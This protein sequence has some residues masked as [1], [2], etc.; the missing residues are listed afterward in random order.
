MAITAYFDG[1]WNDEAPAVMAVG[2]FLSSEKRWRWFED[3]WAKLLAEFG[4][5]YFQMREFTTCSGQF[6]GWKAREPDRREFIRRATDLIGKVAWQS[7]AAAV[8]KDDWN[9]CNEGYALDENRFYPYPLCGWACIQHVQIWC[10]NQKRPYPLGQ[11]LYFFEKDDPNQDDLRKRA[12][13]D[14]GIAIRTPKAIP[15]DLTVRPLAGC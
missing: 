15:D 6:D 12:E 11:V 5:K 9:F 3:R 2:G 8:L 1:S 4:L 13:I 10:Q 14:F 7:V